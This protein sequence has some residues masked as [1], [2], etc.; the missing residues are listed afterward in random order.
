MGYFDVVLSKDLLDGFGE[1][2]ME[3]EGYVEC[4]LSCLSVESC[5]G[6]SSRR[7]EEFASYFVHDSGD[8]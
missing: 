4:V 3:G 6:L 2:G 7:V 8:E 5:E 1:G